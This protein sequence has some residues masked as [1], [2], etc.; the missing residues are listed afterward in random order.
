MFKDYATEFDLSHVGYDSSLLEPKFKRLFQMQQL[1]PAIE[2]KSLS[3]TLN[4]LDPTLPVFED[5]QR[6]IMF[7]QRQRETVKELAVRS[8]KAR[9]VITLKGKKAAPEEDINFE[10][11][12]TGPPLSPAGPAGGPSSRKVEVE[13]AKITSS[14][15]ELLAMNNETVAEQDSP[16]QGED[17]LS[18]TAYRPPPEQDRILALWRS[19]QPL[20]EFLLFF[21]FMQDANEDIPSTAMSIISED[22]SQRESLVQ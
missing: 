18:Y 22:M 17:A 5:T 15:T 3:K 12:P 8:Q 1:S 21:A 19:Q 7:F 2:V 9:K 16:R 14:R 20:G 10:D 13:M 6:E 11:L 4:Q